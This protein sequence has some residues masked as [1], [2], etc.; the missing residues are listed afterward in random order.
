MCI[1]KQWKLPRTRM[2]KLIGLGVD[3]YYA[4]TI[5]NDRKGY[6]LNAGNKAVN[7][8]LR[9]ERLI[10]WGYYDLAT[11]YQSMHVNY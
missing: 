11:A 4:A 6:W 10:S 2:R 9:K 3:S 1:W 7:W 5:A 8:A